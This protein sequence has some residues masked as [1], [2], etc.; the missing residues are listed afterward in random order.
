[1]CDGSRVL[2]VFFEEL[3]VVS[4]HL[5][6]AMAQVALLTDGWSHGFIAGACLRI[7]VSDEARPSA[8][9]LHYYSRSSFC[10]NAYA[11][12]GAQTLW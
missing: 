3:A 5:R 9:T 12:F 1:M 2:V 4:E 8:T 11:E 6:S 10:S 7:K